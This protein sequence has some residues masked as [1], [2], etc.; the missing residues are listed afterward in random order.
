MV[1]AKVA[2]ELSDPVWMNEYGEEVSE[3]D[4]TGYKVTHDLSTQRCVL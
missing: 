2:V 4:A 3:E 1:E